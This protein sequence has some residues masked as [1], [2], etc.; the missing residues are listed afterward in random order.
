MWVRKSDD[1]IRSQRR[2]DRRRPLAPIAFAVLSAACALLVSVGGYKSSHGLG[3]RSPMPLTAALPGVLVLSLLVFLITYV[4]QFLFPGWYR[5]R[6]HQAFICPRCTSV[7]TDG[8]A[9]TCTCG[10]SLEPLRL[11]RWQPEPEA[12][13]NT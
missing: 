12:T 2:R 5:E 6:R 3:Y 13:P 1:E 9:S 7:Y 10:A 4:I 11:W 8:T